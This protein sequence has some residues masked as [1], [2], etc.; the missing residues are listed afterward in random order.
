[1]LCGTCHGCYNRAYLWKHKQNCHS[2]SPAAESIPVSL[3][4]IP[5]ASDS[6]KAN[7]LSSFVSDDVGKICQSDPTI[8]LQGQS[9]YTKIA[10]KPNKKSSV[11]H[12]VMANMEYKEFKDQKRPCPS[13]P[14]MSVDILECRNFP[15]LEKAIQLYTSSRSQLKLD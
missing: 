10:Q 5:S 14:A 4:R 15:A 13:N 9:V 3:F 12:S 11:K 7:I 6:F 2:S 1:M 8:L